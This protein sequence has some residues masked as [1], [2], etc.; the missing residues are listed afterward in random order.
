MNIRSSAISSLL[1][2]VSLSMR[3][4]NRSMDLAMWAT[5]SLEPWKAEFPMC[6]P[7][8]STSGFIP[9]RLGSSSASRTRA[10][11]PDPIIIPFLLL[12]KGRAALVTSLSVVRAPSESRLDPNH[13]SELSEDGSS[14]PST[15]TLLHLP[16]W[17]QSCPIATARV[18]E[19]QA[20]LTCV[21]GP[22]ALRNWANCE[23]PIA[24]TMNM[25]CLGN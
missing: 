22:F 19:A 7:R 23:C 15:N 6:V 12:S 2:P 9:L 21:L 5:S 24:S 11:A 25:K 13:S 17:I 3:N 16:A 8:I 20:E 4:M 18:D 1:M 10:A 14:A